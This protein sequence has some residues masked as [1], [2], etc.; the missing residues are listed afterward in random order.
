MKSKSKNANSILEKNLQAA[1]HKAL[2]LVPTRVLISKK[3]KKK[4]ARRL[5]VQTHDSY[6]EK[7]LRAIAL[8]KK[9]DKL[10]GEL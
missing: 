10:L 6:R 7:S 9:L 1:M 5:A 3:S 2:R 8:A 4:R